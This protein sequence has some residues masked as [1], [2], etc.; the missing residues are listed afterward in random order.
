MAELIPP[1]NSCLTRMTTGEKRLARRIGSHL[2]DDYLCWYETGVGLR[3]SY[4]DFVILHPMRGLLLLEVKDWRL[5][6]I[7]KANPNSFELLVST[8]LK[9]VANP[10]KQARLCAYKLKEQ[11]ERDLQLVHP[12]GEHQGKL[13]MPYGYGVVLTNITRAQYHEAEL[14][15]VL[16]EVQTLCAC[17]R[18]QSWCCPGM[19]KVPRWRF[20]RSSTSWIWSRKSW[21]AAWGPDTAS[22]MALPAPARQ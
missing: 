22:S 12:S 21:R 11:L 1:L 14:D 8:G 18:K 15:R 4:T 2:E 13:I 5:D 9:N 17:S 6:T 7:R 16:P 20:R 10:L 19:R 3:P